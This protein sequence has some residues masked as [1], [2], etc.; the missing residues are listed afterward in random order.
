MH[1]WR[2]YGS[3]L[4]MRFVSTEMVRN[5]I[6]SQA[7]RVKYMKYRSALL[8]NVHEYSSFPLTDDLLFSCMIHTHDI[9]STLILSGDGFAKRHHIGII[10]VHSTSDQRLWCQYDVVLMLIVVTWSTILELIQT[11]MW[12]C[13]KMRYSTQ[14]FFIRNRFIRNQ[15]SI[16]F[17]IKKLS[18]HVPSA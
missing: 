17:R 13:G 9:L 18:T 14:I 12:F 1:C 6:F 2:K 10:R 4:L 3:T 7:F 16:F 11:I 5:S 15:Y 8:I